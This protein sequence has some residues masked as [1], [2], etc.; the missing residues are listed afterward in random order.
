M[1][2]VLIRGLPGSGKTTLGKRIVLGARLE[3]LR[4]INHEADHFFEKLGYFDGALLAQAHG[5]CLERFTHDISSGEQDLVVVSNTFTT[6]KEMLPYMEACVAR[7]IIPQVITC[8]GMFGSVHSVP[9]TTIERMRAR[10]E[11]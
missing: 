4:A 11:E 6:Q 10:W 5:Q 7:S 1:Q 2:V 9:Q 8:K 3:N